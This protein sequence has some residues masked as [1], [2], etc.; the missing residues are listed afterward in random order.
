M[1]EEDN[2]QPETMMSDHQ[3]DLTSQNWTDMGVP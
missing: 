2:L 3:L 1:L